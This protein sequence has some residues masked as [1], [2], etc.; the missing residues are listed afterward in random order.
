MESVIKSANPILKL[1]IMVSL[2]GF[3]FGYDAVVISGV[4]EQ[5]TRQY[6]LSVSEQGFLVA[7]P[8]LTA[9][10][11]T[12]TA[13]PLS[14]RYGRKPLLITVASLY[15]VSAL[16]ST[17]SINPYMLT[18]GRAMGGLAF[19]SLVLGPLYISE[20]ARAHHR[21]RMVSMNQIAIVIGLSTAYFS[22][23]LVTSISTHQANGDLVLLGVLSWRWMFGL[24]LIPA[25]IW[26]GAL[27]KIPETP[28]WLI[29]HKR[30][31]EA[32]G[33]LEKLHSHA[34][35]KEVFDRISAL[36][37][38]E[39]KERT[40]L[41]SILHT[42]AFKLTF[43]IALTV[44]VAQQITGV[45]A[46][47][48]YAPTVFHQAGADVNASMIQASVIGV[49]NLVFTFV[50][51]ALVDRIGRKP[52]MLMGLSGIMVSMVI[53]GTGF[54]MATYT[55]S[56][57]ALASFPVDVQSGLLPLMGQTFSSDLAYN[58]ALHQHLDIP[59]YRVHHNALIEVAI[60]INGPLV[61]AGLCLFVA[62]FASSV[63]PVMWVFL[64]EIFPGPVRGFAVAGV[65]ALNSLTSFLVQLSFPIELEW[66]G[67]ASTFWFYGVSAAFFALV[68]WKLMP[69]T[70]GI[71]L[72][73]I[74]S[75]LSR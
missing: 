17:F 28:R 64:S 35:A 6:S 60:D 71:S 47:Y 34:H 36:I 74:E 12:L 61:L 59:S 37:K 30:E 10:L 8:T 27:L 73:R 43:L 16:I 13:G 70:K 45:N 18:L 51:F 21:G 14:D 20:T 58:A 22:N 69:E 68:L 15:I 38:R 29:T 46:I 48:F 54:S 5:A 31:K 19:S 9:I 39:Q 65:A 11:G 3:V 72:E 66:I 40:S 67:A 4:I 33:L 49:I 62:S 7:V 1:A 32:L 75:R 2:G 25:L 52:L 41:G 57:E 26:L 50:A 56:A 44:A 53:V 55:L 23:L 63:G 42:R 24:E